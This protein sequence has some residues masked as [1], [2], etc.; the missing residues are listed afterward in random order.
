[1]INDTKWWGTEIRT[2][3]SS[4]SSAPLFF[5]FLKVF[6]SIA[7]PKSFF[8]KPVRC[9]TLRKPSYLLK[10]TQMSP[11]LEALCVSPIQSVSSLQDSHCDLLTFQ[12][13]EGPEG[14]PFRD[15][16]QSL[17]RSSSLYYLH[18]DISPQEFHKEVSVILM[19]VSFSLRRLQVQA[20]WVTPH[21]MD[22]P[23]PGCPILLRD[24]FY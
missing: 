3:F 10:S 19:R 7:L 16:S 23:G 2:S 5:L 20:D 8:I 6:L 9:L 14:S 21:I 12:M 22:L 13:T 11:S 17:G 4:L 15:Y 18:S 24:G 1:M